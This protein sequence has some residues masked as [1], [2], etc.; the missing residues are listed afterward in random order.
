M[1]FWETRARAEGRIPA[2]QGSVII[3]ACFEKTR[4]M[5][6]K[7]PSPTKTVKCGPRA[8]PWPLTSPGSWYHHY[9]SWPYISSAIRQACYAQLPRTTTIH[10]FLFC[11]AETV[12]SNRN[13]KAHSWVV[14]WLKQSQPHAVSKT[15]L[16]MYL[17]PHWERMKKSTANKFSYPWTTWE[18]WLFLA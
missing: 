6:N 9:S 3:S 15:S 13:L 12:K 2:P 18:I 5:G 10:F 4:H 11:T 14:S 17:P 1:S 7:N 8:C 16:L